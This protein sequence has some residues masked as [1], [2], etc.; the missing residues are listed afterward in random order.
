MEK[1]AEKLNVKP[2]YRVVSKLMLRVIGLF[3]PLMRESVE[4]NYQYDRD[5]VFDSSK[6]EKEF[7]FKPT[8]YEDGVDAIV[9]ADYSMNRQTN[10]KKY[11][12]SNIL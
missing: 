3:A 4:M 7:N 10:L 8:S 9:R 11:L 1:I 12:K 5:Y 2:K 6:F